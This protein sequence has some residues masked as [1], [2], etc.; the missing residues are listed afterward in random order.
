MLECRYDDE[1]VLVPS[2]SENYKMIV[3]LDIPVSLEDAS[4]YGHPIYTY[5]NFV[6]GI[7]KKDETVSE[8]EQKED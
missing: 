4:H 3:H 1:G 5:C 6:A 2:D 7:R 8:T